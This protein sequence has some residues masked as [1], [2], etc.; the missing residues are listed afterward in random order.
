MFGRKKKVP[1]IEPKEEYEN[2]QPDLEVDARTLEVN[3]NSEMSEMSDDEKLSRIENLKSNIAKIQEE[4]IEQEKKLKKPIKIEETEE[5]REVENKEVPVATPEASPQL[6][7]YRNP[8]NLLLE[9]REPKK[10]IGT[11]QIQGMKI[12]PNGLFETIV[13]ST[14]SLGYLGQMFDLD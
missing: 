11:A 9:Q 5:V 13:Y 6:E 10:P 8:R 12:L 3:E 7:T 14:E 2:L 1:E 4:I